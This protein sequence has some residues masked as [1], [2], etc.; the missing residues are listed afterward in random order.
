MPLPRHAIPMSCRASITGVIRSL[1]FLISFPG[2]IGVGLF[3]GTEISSQKLLASSPFHYHF[4]FKLQCH[5]VIAI[6]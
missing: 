1:T 5:L 3:H 4:N 2:E 6:S